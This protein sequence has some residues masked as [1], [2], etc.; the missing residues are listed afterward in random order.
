V[1]IT[2]GMVEVGISLVGQVV[3][4]RY[5]IEAQL[6]RGAMGTVYR[7]RHLKVGREVAIKIMH[8]ELTRDAAMVARFERE[9]AIAARLDHRNVVGVL[10][11][12]ETPDGQKL[13]VLELAR[14]ETLA[15]MLADGP[16]AAARVVRLVGELLRGL[17]HAHAAGLVHRDL[18]PD[19]VIVERDDHGGEVPRILDFGIA[20][21]RDG[22]DTTAGR[23][24][25]ETGTVLGTPPYMAPEQALGDAPDPRTDLFA[26]GVMAYELLCGCQPFEGTG[27]EIMVA[28]VNCEPPR[29]AERVP[30]CAVEPALEAFVRTLMAR[31]L[32]DRFASATAAL[33]ALRALPALD[34]APRRPAYA[35]ARRPREA[36]PAL[37]RP[38]RPTTR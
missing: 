15:A 12:G 33:A 36:L 32:A 22:D 4:E 18:K 17:E 38:R 29:F 8:P 26:L 20:V 37:S 10:D 23:R 31:R 25:T 7:A 3:E 16:L 28:N 21:L 27:V 35:T 9:A 13:M 30:G 1:A 19:N 5:R 2:D 14:G 6:G 11:V 34:A 24:L